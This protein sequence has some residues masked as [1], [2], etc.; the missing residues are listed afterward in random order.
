M[1]LHVSRRDS[2]LFQQINPKN[3]TAEFSSRSESQLSLHYRS[4]RVIIQRRSG[5]CQC[6]D[7]KQSILDAINNICISFTHHDEMLEAESL[8]CCL[9]GISFARKNYVLLFLV[10]H[11]VLIGTIGNGKNMRCIIR[12]GFEHVAIVE[13]KI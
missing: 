8:I 3:R 12:T 5:M 1:P 4:C 9:A 6:I 2:R 11:H 13:L 10:M 7:S